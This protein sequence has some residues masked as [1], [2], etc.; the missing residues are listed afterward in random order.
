M[1]VS[2]PKLESIL[3]GRSFPSERFSIPS[4]AVGQDTHPTRL[5]DITFGYTAEAAT[6]I[7]VIDDAS[8]IDSFDRLAG[9]LPI[10]DIETDGGEIPNFYT[11]VV[12]KHQY[13]T[14]NAIDDT[15]EQTLRF[16]PKRVPFTAFSCGKVTSLE[17]HVLNIPNLE[18]I[19][20]KITL[21]H[22]NKT[23]VINALNT[24]NKNDNIEYGVTHAINIT[25]NSE[26]TDNDEIK[27]LINL[28]SNFLTFV[29][30]QYTGIGHL[31]GR[32]NQNEDVLFQ[33]GF[34]KVDPPQKFQG[35]FRLDPDI[36]LKKLFEGFSSLSKH[37]SDYLAVIRALDFYRAA[38]FVGP[39]AREVALIASCSGVEAISSYVLREKGGWSKNLLNK[40][41][42]S[43]KIRAATRLIGL[44]ENLFNHCPELEARL[45]GKHHDEFELLALFRNKIIHSD[46]EFTY[47]GIELYEAY[48]VYQ[49]LIEMFVFFMTRYGNGITDRRKR[50]GYTETVQVP[51]RFGT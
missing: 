23:I 47:S 44:E 3:H 35:W 38:N 50:T 18:L 5:R 40:A 25:S 37:T 7:Y 17:M 6:Y 46:N 32:N 28:I 48:N 10:L 1:S 20:N 30:G 9:S 41:A 21:Q 43:D 27:K 2:A 8:V 11:S 36:R 33:P 39:A 13:C 12:T 22:E 26:F 14:T 4:V 34:R 15:Q 42:L 16:C 45:I 49:W 19:S 31:T 24:S 51:I 29:S